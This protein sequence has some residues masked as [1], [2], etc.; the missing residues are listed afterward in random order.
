MY[1]CRSVVHSVLFSSCCNLCHLVGNKPK[2]SGPGYRMEPGKWERDRV[3]RTLYPNTYGWYRDDPAEMKKMASELK[4][5]CADFWPS[6]WA[7]NWSCVR[8]SVWSSVWLFVRPS[9]CPS[10]DKY[11]INF[12]YLSNHVQIWIP[13]NEKRPLNLTSF[14]E[15]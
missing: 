7:C 9:V 10:R 4:V 8:L 14:W 6:I 1:L 12:L 2:W 13:E 5:S 11:I 3:Y 15:N